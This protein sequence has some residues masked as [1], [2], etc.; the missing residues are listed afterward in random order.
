MAPNE[1][2]LL[3]YVKEVKVDILDMGQVYI[4]YSKVICKV[5]FGSYIKND[6]IKVK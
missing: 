2:G 1:L 5:T 3:S 4:D 6:Q